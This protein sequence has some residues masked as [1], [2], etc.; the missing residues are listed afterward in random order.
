MLDLSKDLDGLKDIKYKEL[1]KDKVG[2]EKKNQYLIKPTLIEFNKLLEREL[3]MVCD[4]L[5]PIKYSY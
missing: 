4:S 5:V 1:L 2:V 3:T